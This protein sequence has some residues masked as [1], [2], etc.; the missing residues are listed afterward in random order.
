MLLAQ[1]CH[2][3]IIGINAVVFVTGVFGAC[4]AKINP[5]YHAAPRN[6]TSLVAVPTAAAGAV[7]ANVHSTQ[8]AVK[9]TNRKQGVVTYEVFHDV[10]LSA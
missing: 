1:M 4:G 2:K 9:A 6:G 10:N 3:G 8:P 5:V 7:A